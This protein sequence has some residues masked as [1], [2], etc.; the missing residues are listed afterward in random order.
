MAGVFAPLQLGVGVSGG[1]EAAVHRY[2]STMPD[3]HVVVKLDFTNAFNSL[4]RDCML[5]AIAR[6]V[7]ELY[8]FVYASYTVE[9]ILQHGSGTVRSREGPQQGDPL[10]P[11]EF[12]CTIHPL[13]ERLR[14]ELRIGFLDIL[15]LGGDSDIV[16]SDVYLIEKEAAAFGL[17]LNKS[18]PRS[19]GL[20]LVM[21]SL[22]ML[23][24]ASRLKPWLRP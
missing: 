22:Q 7:P 13:L 5:E 19:R 4:R 15:T 11:L 9:P 18:R 6:D 3:I 12:C 17:T 8:R 16:V 10:G 23:C 21:A 14:S 20:V 2:L 1:A 24:L